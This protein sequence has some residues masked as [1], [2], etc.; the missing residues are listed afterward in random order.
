MVA[1]IKAATT[2]TGTTVTE[3]TKSAAKIEIGIGMTGIATRKPAIMT[4]IKIR[5]KIIPATVTAV[6][7][8]TMMTIVNAGWRH[9]PSLR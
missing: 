8:M 4:L 5:I 6:I 3:N 2:V 7:A 1:L 9:H